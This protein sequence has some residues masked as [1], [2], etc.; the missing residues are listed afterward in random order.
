[1]SHDQ[2]E[3]VTQMSY[4]TANDRTCKRTVYRIDTLSGKTMK[5]KRPKYSVTCIHF[6]C[7][8]ISKLEWGNYSPFANQFL[9]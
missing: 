4:S 8:P 6:W 9:N 7:Y 1:M 5:N 2:V 3:Q